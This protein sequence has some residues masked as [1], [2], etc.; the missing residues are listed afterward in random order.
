MAP[1]TNLNHVGSKVPDECLPSRPL[2]RR[3]VD[4]IVVHAHTAGMVPRVYNDTGV[5]RP[6]AVGQHRWHEGQLDDGRDTSG[7]NAII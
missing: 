1:P 6:G 5:R 4:M 3:L 2:C 7:K